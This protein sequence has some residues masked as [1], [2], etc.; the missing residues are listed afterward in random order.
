MGLNFL[1]ENGC[2]NGASNFTPWIT[3]E[4]LDF[5]AAFRAASIAKITH[6]GMVTRLLCLSEHSFAK[7]AQIG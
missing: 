5:V 6:G 4:G 3:L 1:T 7:A 2:R